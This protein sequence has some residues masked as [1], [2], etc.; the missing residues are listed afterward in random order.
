[1]GYADDDD[2]LMNL[3]VTYT[4]QP[5]VVRVGDNVTFTCRY[6]MP[7][8]VTQFT[9]IHSLKINKHHAFYVYPDV[10]NQYNHKQAQAVEPD[11]KGY[12]RGQIVT[13][14]GIREG[15]SGWYRCTLSIPRNRIHID[16]HG[17]VYVTV[18]SKYIRLKSRHPP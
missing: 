6:Q 7:V 10:L 13:F 3:E 15:M 1:M 12:R 14:Q 2:M 17:A 9:V 8:N 18:V 16:V 5:Q 11:D 4:A